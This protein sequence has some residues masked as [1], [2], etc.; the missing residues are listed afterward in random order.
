MNKEVHIEELN[1]H[2]KCYLVKATKR[3]KEMI[4]KA[5]RDLEGSATVEE[6][7]E[8][9]LSVEGASEE[10]FSYWLNLLETNLETGDSLYPTTLPTVLGKFRP[11]QLL[12]ENLPMRR[13]TQTDPPKYIVFSCRQEE[14]FDRAKHIPLYEGYVC[15]A[16]SRWEEFAKYGY[17]QALPIALI[18]RDDSWIVQ[19]S[20]YEFGFSVAWKWWENC[21]KWYFE[22]H[23]EWF[24]DD[25]IWG[26]T[27]EQT[28]EQAWSPPGAAVISPSSLPTYQSVEVYDAD[29]SRIV[30]AY[31]GEESEKGYCPQNSQARGQHRVSPTKLHP[32]IAGGA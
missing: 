10:V 31:A 19:L 6:V 18:R 15:V 27:Q 1:R 28:Q 14:G 5:I 2:L 16:S 32:A 11:N 8:I 29:A 12:A 25:P 17:A 22:K 21:R 30:S 24:W 4:T 7:K 23:P 26:E 20:V 3:R 9:L 13:D